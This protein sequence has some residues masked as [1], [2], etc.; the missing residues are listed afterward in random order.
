M[1]DSNP[2]RRVLITRLSHIGDCVLTLPLACAIKDQDPDSTIVWVCE[3]PANQLLEQHRA[4]DQLVVVPRGYL[5]SIRALRRLR[6]SLQSLDCQVAIDPQSLTKSSVAGWL[7]G[8]ARRIGFRGKFGRELAPYLHN[9]GIVPKSTHLVDRTLELLEPLGLQRTDPVFDLQPG[10]AADSAVRQFVA[11]SHLGCGF[12]VL[13]PGASWESKRWS[14]RKFARVARHLGEQHNIPSLVTW[15]GAE[16]RSWAQQVV[17]RSGGHAVLAA[18]T[19]LTELASLMQHAHFFVGSDTG[20]LHIAGAM[21]TPC[22]GLYGPTRPQDSGAYG[23]GHIA[24]QAFYQ[25]G[26]R[27]TR[28]TNRTA[29]NAIDAESVIDACELMI[30]RH[31]VTADRNAA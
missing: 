11:A 5:R 6:S 14:P 27:R 21:K 23:P 19:S 15:A 22:I 2:Q 24:V 9:E 1:N 13:N 8:A 4:V 28:R 20:P 26:D 29:M 7:S 18:P 16:E 3:K 25:S 10:E 17:D 31:S 30:S 12:V